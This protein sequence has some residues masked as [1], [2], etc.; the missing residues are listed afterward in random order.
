MGKVTNLQREI[1]KACTKQR[2]LLVVEGSDDSSYY[3]NFL[4][5]IAIEGTYEVLEV[6][7]FGK[8]AGCTQIVEQLTEIQDY[9]KNNRYLLKYFRGIIDADVFHLV[10][11]EEVMCH[12][13]NL[14]GLITLKY[15]SYESHALTRRNIK[16][17][18]AMITYCQPTK[19][20]D[21]VMDFVMNDLDTKVIQQ[22]YYVGLE[23]LR[24]A[25]EKEYQSVSSYDASE[26][27]IGG[28][29]STETFTRKQSR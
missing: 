19:L 11:T 20:T 3:E 14:L 7:A 18:L 29:Q 26:S 6:S 21:D 9:V 4:K 2:C 17:L 12:R 16:E 5:K 1:I 24:N 13:K 15:Y 22:M 27:C 28:L 10:A 23:C 25:V 8:G